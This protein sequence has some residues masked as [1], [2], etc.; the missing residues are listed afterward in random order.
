M[1]LKVYFVLFLLV[2]CSV[3]SAGCFEAPAETFRFENLDAP[4]GKIVNSLPILN[5][6]N[7]PTG[8]VLLQHSIYN[9][10]FPTTNCSRPWLL[11]MQQV[12]S[13]DAVIYGHIKEVKEAVW[14][15]EDG[16][17]PEGYMAPTLWTDEDGRAHVRYD[18]DNRG[19]I[20]YT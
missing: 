1:K 6:Y 20:L 9:S 4:G 19:H 5:L 14:D 15:T 7:F 18:T 8:K 13:A 2:L 10:G 3:V 11:P 12:E 16:K 17:A